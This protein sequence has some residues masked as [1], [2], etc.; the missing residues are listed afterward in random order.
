MS[1][2]TTSPSA[3]AGTGAAAQVRQYSWTRAA[4]PDAS[5]WSAVDQQV[6]EAVEVPAGRADEVLV[7]RR[8]AQEQVEIVLPRVADAAVDLDAVLEDAA[9]GF[10]GRGLGDVAGPPAVRVVGVDAHRR[11]VHRRSRP[12]ERERHLRELVL[13]RLEAADRHVELLAFLRVRERH[14]EDLAS[15]AH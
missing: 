2:I 11:V 1:S 10:A 8:S 13:D 12:L 14:R 5:T 7:G 3:S 4:V 15:R 9:R 6:G